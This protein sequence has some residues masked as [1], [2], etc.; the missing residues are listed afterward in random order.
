MIHF[1]SDSQDDVLFLNA[2]KSLPHP[3]E[4]AQRASRRTHRADPNCPSRDVHGPIAAGSAFVRRQLEEALQLGEA[5]QLEMPD[6]PDRQVEV[7]GKG[8]RH[9]QR[10]VEL[11]AEMLDP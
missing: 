6:L 2:I 7:F 5:A 11:T 3:E 4:P 8:L 10:A 9:D 1:E